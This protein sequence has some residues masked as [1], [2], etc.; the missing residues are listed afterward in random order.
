MLCS[1]LN[2]VFI[3]EKLIQFFQIEKYSNMKLGLNA[4]WDIIGCNRSTPV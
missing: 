4:C 3:D 2:F 1:E